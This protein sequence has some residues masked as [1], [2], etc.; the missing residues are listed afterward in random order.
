MDYLKIEKN[1]DNIMVITIDCPDTSVN[2]ISS[3]LLN[4]VEEVVVEIEKD[5]K[6]KAI[7][8]TSAKADTFVAGA[9][10]DEL[11]EMRTKD[12]VTAYITKANAILNKLEALPQPVVCAIHGNCLGGGLELALVADYRMASDSPDT[13]FGLP[14]VMLGLMPA[15]GGT[16]RMPDL[17]GL[18]TALP[19][20]LA[21]KQLRS[22]KA[23]KIGLIDEIVPPHG[24][25]EA[26]IKAAGKLAQGEIKKRE[27]KRP[28]IMKLLEKYQAGRNFVFK[29]AVDGV[30]KQTKGIYPAPLEII[31]S[32]KYGTENGI[33]KGIQADV[34]RFSKLVLSP[35]ASSLTSL[36][37]AMNDRKKNPMEDIAVPVKKIGILGAGLMGHGIAGASTDTCDTILLKDLSLEAAAKGVKEITKGLSI[38]A[39]SG[40]MTKFDSLVGGAK[41]IP[42]DNFNSFKGCDL[43]VE[44]VFE[45]LD[46]KKKMLRDV[47]AVTG[48]KTIF[49]TNTS[50]LPIGEIAKG[51]K[52]PG[53]VIGMHYF[54]PVRSMPLL[55]IITT[56]ETEDW[57]T[58]TAID[59]GIKQGKTCIVVKDGP[60]FYTTRI[61]VL[62]LNEA[63]FLVEEG[64][65]IHTIDEAMMTFGFPVGPIK[66]IDEVGIDIGAH[67]GEFLEKSFSDRDIQYSGVIKKLFANGFLGRKN[68]KGFYQYTG[69]KGKKAA[70]TEAAKIINST[71]MKNVNI[72]ELQFRIGLAMINEAVLCLQEGIISSPE[73]G[74]VGAILGL[75]FPPLKGGP[76]RYVDNYGPDKILNLLNDYQSRFGSRFKP[77]DYL[78]DLVK[79][80]RRFY[81]K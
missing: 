45:D 58:A 9:D 78:V 30:M 34:D 68:K 48:D 61:L 36:F 3:P 74:D 44:A 43:V 56:D 19:L 17:I 50:S 49:A 79:S 59:F 62:M 77:A 40:G 28:L 26:A 27:I 12:E 69:K 25:K 63:M 53:N 20:I 76:F 2:K 73:D 14:E 60:A 70:N 37:F 72:E 7:V 81:Q 21:G 22:K 41:V 16:Q 8:I 32:I 5:P 57:V 54:S 11:K 4:E 18:T 13:V 71:K 66:L 31:E 10:L 33:E 39:K 35:V 52:R 80:G 67:V 75:G 51:C 29:K 55:E 64:V 24:M 65:D 46:L 15:A 38:R 47:E 6:L 42:C 1:K 23:L